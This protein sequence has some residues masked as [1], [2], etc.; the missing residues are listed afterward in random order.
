MK[1]ESLG[2][3]RKHMKNICG[4]SKLYSNF[5]TRM[6]A[7]TTKTS[8]MTFFQYWTQLPHYNQ[9][10][11]KDTL[12]NI[13]HEKLISTTKV[14]FSWKIVSFL[15]DNLWFN[16][17]FQTFSWNFFYVALSLPLYFSFFFPPTLECVWIFQYCTERIQR[18]DACPS[19][20][21]LTGGRHVS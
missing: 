13:L 4:S 7:L 2:V 3:E 1:K 5:S 15:A 21:V 6:Q 19:L 11:S 20:C 8:E 10:M 16:I 12:T 18:H 17:L 9:C 14:T